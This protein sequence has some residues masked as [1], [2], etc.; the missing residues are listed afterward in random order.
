MLT[1]YGACLSFVSHSGELR[2][3]RV[4]WELQNEGLRTLEVASGVQCA[5]SL[6]A[7]SWAAPAACGGSQARG[8]I[9]AVATGLHQSHSNAGSGPHLQPTPQPTAMPDPQPTEQGQGSNPQLHGSWLDSST[10][11]PRRELPIYTFL[12]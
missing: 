12:I 3:R 1:L 7:I 11:V 2:N 4:T 6:F 8:R 10:T 9:R 5:G